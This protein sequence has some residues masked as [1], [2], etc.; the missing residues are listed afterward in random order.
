[1]L[2]SLLPSLFAKRSAA[3][4]SH[5]QVVLITNFTSCKLGL[6]M[7]D[8]LAKQE[9]KVIAMAH[10]A[11]QVLERTSSAVTAFDGFP[12]ES[13]DRSRLIAFLKSHKY[14]VVTLVQN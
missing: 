2:K 9:L 4:P 7:V 5:Q 3:S 1:M 14:Q 11:E 12:N 8:Q 13:E 6:A 10:N